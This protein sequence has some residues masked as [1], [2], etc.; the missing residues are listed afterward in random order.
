MRIDNLRI[1]AAPLHLRLI[2]VR[3]SE[4]GRIAKSLKSIFFG[5]QGDHGLIMPVIC[6]FRI[7]GQSHHIRLVGDDADI[8]RIL[9]HFVEVCLHLGSLFA[10]KIPADRLR[11]ISVSRLVTACQQKSIPLCV[12]LLDPLPLQ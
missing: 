12:P 4:L 1:G 8:L 9:Q 10:D 7:I 11:R 2:A 6:K 5:H 3:H